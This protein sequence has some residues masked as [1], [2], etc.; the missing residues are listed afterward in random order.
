[1]NELLAYEYYDEDTGYR[2]IIAGDVVALPGAAWSYH[3]FSTSYVISEEWLRRETKLNAPE[4]AAVI[5]GLLYAQEM[6]RTKVK[7]GRK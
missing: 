1:M 4:R 6:D 5:R 2:V 3:G 7:G